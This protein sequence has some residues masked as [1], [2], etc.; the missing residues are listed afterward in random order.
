MAKRKQVVPWRPTR[1]QQLAALDRRV[2]DVIAPDLDVLFCGINPGLYSAAVGHHF[3]G[4]GNLFWRTLSGAGFTPRLLSAFEE[5]ELLSLGYGITNLVS[6]SSAAADEVS[7]E[8]LRAGARTLRR[9]VLKFTPRFL[10]VCGLVAYR[11]GFERPKARVGL[12]AERIGAT[13]IWLLPNPSGLNA[14]HSPSVLHQ[15][16]EDLRV[17]VKAARVARTR[18]D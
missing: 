6:R 13:A 11:L 4:P 3:A 18:P 7:K 17:A 9:K 1:K 10:A 16:F 14:F 2:P 12:Q 5:H 15:M 8:E